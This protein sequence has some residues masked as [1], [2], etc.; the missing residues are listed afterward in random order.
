MVRR[1]ETRPGTQ[2]W[3][4]REIDEGTPVSLTQALREAPGPMR[5]LGQRVLVLGRGVRVCVGIHFDPI[6]PYLMAAID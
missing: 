1:G 5:P 4:K 2:A 3:Q 6:N